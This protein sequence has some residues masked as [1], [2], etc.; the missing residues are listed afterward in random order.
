M[1]VAWLGARTQEHPIRVRPHVTAA[2][3]H[4]KRTRARGM[5]REA[6]VPRRRTH[7]CRL[8]FFGKPNSFC[9][10]FRSTSILLAMHT[11]GMPGLRAHHQGRGVSGRATASGRINPHGQQKS[12]LGGPGMRPMTTSGGT[13]AAR[14]LHAPWASWRAARKHRD[15][16]FRPGGATGTRAAPCTNRAGS[17][18]SAEGEA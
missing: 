8:C 3:R 11:T 12:A 17:C 7:T 4:A 2:K 16:S 14:P 15:D 1:S 6:R 10:T 9:V 13:T 5:R 18:T